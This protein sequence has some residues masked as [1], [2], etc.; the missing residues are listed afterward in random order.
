[1]REAE[2]RP[3]S[4]PFKDFWLFCEK[5]QEK[6]AYLVSP[7]SEKAAIRGRLSGCI[8]QR[9]LSLR[10]SADRIGFE[11][12]N[13]LVAGELDSNSSSNSMMAEAEVRPASVP[14]RDFW[15]FCGKMQEKRP[16]LVSPCSENAAIRGPL[17]GCIRQR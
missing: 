6:R 3:A 14:S 7:C 13:Q 4:V 10:W 17:T 9:R 2:V 8:Q 1:M 5:K 15:L 16:S 11:H 12:Q